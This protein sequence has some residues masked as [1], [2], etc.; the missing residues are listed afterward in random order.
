M[1]C[2]CNGFYVACKVQRSPSVFDRSSL[3]QPKNEAVGLSDRLFLPGLNWEN[4][5]G[6][7][8]TEQASVEDSASKRNLTNTPIKKGKQACNKYGKTF[9]P[10]YDNKREATN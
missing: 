7:E 9:P 3:L 5:Q 10:R 6:L 1:Q 8:I 4:Q 2:L